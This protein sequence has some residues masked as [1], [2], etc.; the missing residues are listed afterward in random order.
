MDFKFNNPVDIRFGRNAVKNNPG[1]LALGK[2]AYIVTGSSSG[3]RSGALA[4]VEAA[5]NSS[6]IRYQVFEGIQNN[7]NVTQCREL[8]CAARTFGADFVIGIGGGSPLDAAKAVAV[9]ASN[10]ELETEKLFL[11]RFDVKPLPIAA[12]PTTSGTGSEATPWSIMTW[13]EFRSKKSFGNLATYPRI[14]LLDPSYTDSLPIDFTRYTAMDAFQHCFENFLSI[15]SNPMTD[16]L[17]LYALA[18]FSRCMGPLEKGEAS[19]IRDELMLISLLGGVTISQTGTTMMHAMGY[20]LTYY[21]G[22]PHGKANSFVLPVYLEETAKYVPEKLNA[23]LNAMN[24]G[25]EELKNYFLRNFPADFKARRDE[26]PLWGELTMQQG[27]VKNL[28][29]PVSAAY[30]VSL[31]ERIFKI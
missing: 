27:S 2:N 23:A 17:N 8:G 31:Y 9:F 6:G 3:R 21:Y 16:A 1:S 22:A 28:P 5:L 19:G 14:A 26:L 13:D 11:N 30:F 25:F 24:I 12:I 15:K 10:P 7:P 4:D 29:V 18:Q 20:P